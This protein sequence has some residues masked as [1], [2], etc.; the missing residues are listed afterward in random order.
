MSS[1]WQGSQ[2]GETATTWWLTRYTTAFAATRGWGNERGLDA[3]L[4]RGWNLDGPDDGVIGPEGEMWESA[5]R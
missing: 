4:C 2:A 1:D 5:S 3:E